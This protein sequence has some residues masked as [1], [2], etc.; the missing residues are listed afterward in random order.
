MNCSRARA[1]FVEWELS[2]LPPDEADAVQAHLESCV[3]CARLARGERALTAGLLRLRVELP[4][5][6]DV[7]ARIMAEISRRGSQAPA[8]VPAR[9]FGWATAA[10]ML[11]AAVLA[12]AAFPSISQLRQVLAASTLAILDLGR[13][14]A[15]ALAPLAPYAQA[16][17]RTVLAF[18]RAAGD[19][20]TAAMHLEPLARPAVVVSALAALTLSSLVIGRDLLARA[21]RPTVKE[22]P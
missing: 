13:A 5:R 7:S 20:I 19:L 16:A 9:H 18:G 11:A 6:M 10:A 2:L 1:S 15:T 22:L 4:Y 21:S 8:R 12:G 17:W 14:M 3:E